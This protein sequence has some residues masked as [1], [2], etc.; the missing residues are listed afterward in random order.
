MKKIGFSAAIN[1]A[2]ETLETD[3]FRSLGA[4]VHVPDLEECRYRRQDYRD[5]DYA[6][7]VIRTASLTGHH[8]GGTCK[9]GKTWKD[10]VVDHRLRYILQNRSKFENNKSFCF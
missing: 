8:P 1:L 7:C 6:E 2:L 3:E 9:I 5:A 4:N 10:S